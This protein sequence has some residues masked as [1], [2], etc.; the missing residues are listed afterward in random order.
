MHWRIMGFQPQDERQEMEERSVVSPHYLYPTV[1]FL[2]G[3]PTRDLILLPER[4]LRDQET[5]THP[6]SL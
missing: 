3:D 2:Q 6:F 1:L 5:H 4:E